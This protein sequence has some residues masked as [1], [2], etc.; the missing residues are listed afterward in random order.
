MTMDKST[1]GN[2]IKYQ[3]LI[4]WL[5]ETDFGNKIGITKQC[6]NSLEHEKTIP[7]I[8]TLKRMADFCGVSKGNFLKE[9]EEIEKIQS[10]KLL[11]DFMK[12]EQ[13]LINK[14]RTL[15]PKRRKAVEI[16][17]GIKNKK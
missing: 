9:T 10:A 3:C 14:L 12:K 13:Q 4:I 16:L 17:F 7:Y 15:T 11:K 2:N 5:T 6:L 8:I 1:I